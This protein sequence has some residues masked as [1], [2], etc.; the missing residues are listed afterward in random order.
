MNVTTLYL[1]YTYNTVWAGSC[2]IDFCQP[3]RGLVTETPWSAVLH[4]A[5]KACASA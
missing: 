3:I 1:S 5:E 2:A 4:S